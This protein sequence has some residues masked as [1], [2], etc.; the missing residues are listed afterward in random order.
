MVHRSVPFENRWTSGDR[1][2]HWM[3]RLERE[4]I[5]NVQAIFTE[6]ELHDVGS[7]LLSEDIPVAFVR[8]WLSWHERSARRARWKHWL[9]VDLLLLLILAAILVVSWQ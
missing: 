7:R 8:E 5:T 4:G 6:H 2:W 1:A 9:I 3:L